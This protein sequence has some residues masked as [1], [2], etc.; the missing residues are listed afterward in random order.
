MAE[1]S[2]VKISTEDGDEFEVVVSQDRLGV[3]LR[4]AA[5]IHENSEI[6]LKRAIEM[7]TDAG[8]KVVFVKEGA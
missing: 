5:E 3:I 1:E 6:D 4:L 8:A 7:L 2:V